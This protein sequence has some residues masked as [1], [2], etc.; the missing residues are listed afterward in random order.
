MKRK[1]ALLLSLIACVG[2]TGNLKAFAETKPVLNAEIA[3][4][5]LGTKLSWT[6]SYGD[7][8]YRV[9]SKSEDESE[10][11]TIP[12]LKTVKV[13]NIYPDKSDPIEGEEPSQ[14][15]DEPAGLKTWME[16]N[17]YG[18]DMITVDSVKLTDFNTEP[19]SY[20]LTD[21]DVIMFGTWNDNNKQDLSQNALEVVKD[22]IELG[23]GV[24]LGH[25]TINYN[26]GELASYSTN[27]SELGVY[28]GISGAPYVSYEDPLRG[29]GDIARISKKGAITTYPYDLGELSSGLDIRY[30]NTASQRASG[31]IWID[32]FYN[33]ASEG[34]FYLT[35][36][37]N[38]GMIQAG[39]TSGE[40]HANDYK[41]IANALM[42]LGQVSKE[43]TGITYAPLDTK[44]PDMPKLKGASLY[45]GEITFS[46]QESEDIGTNYQL[47]VEANDLDS[48]DKTESEILDVNAI[49]GIKGYVYSIDNVPIAIPEGECNA[50]SNT[51]KVDVSTLDTSDSIYLHIKAVDNMNNVSEVLSTESITI[52]PKDPNIAKYNYSNGVLKFNMSETSNTSILKDGV[53]NT[54]AVKYNVEIFKNY[55][56]Y[57]SYEDTSIRECTDLKD[58]DVITGNIYAIDAYGNESEVVPLEYSVGDIKSSLKED[59]ASYIENLV[60]SNDINPDTLKQD[61]LELD[62][63]SSLVVDKITIVNSTKYTKGNLT[64]D[65]SIDGEPLTK[66][67]EIKCDKKRQTKEEY[68][69]DVKDYVDTGEVRQYISSNQESKILEIIKDEIESACKDNSSLGEIEIV[70]NDEKSEGN[71]LEIEVYYNNN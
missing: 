52:K 12:I 46:I 7:K 15:T 64:I 62:S 16:D 8:L 45:D 35:T 53:L 18:K 31:D 44:A 40:M 71:K 24:L 10:F 47:Y 66:S 69:K 48:G 11:K 54:P 26:T 57:E 65:Y 5:S 43:N 70:I 56:P 28:A 67:K 39:H 17:G 59:V 27:F 50:T 42:Y 14:E 41:A 55:A 25:D 2:M 23:Y 58:G 51:V 30:S 33:K 9:F 49:S 37:G 36:K 4:D 20:T 1:L 60:I 3:E 19:D 22:Y 32:F 61:L 6:D 63:A 29:A 34:N 38:V 68:I 13:L 21:Y